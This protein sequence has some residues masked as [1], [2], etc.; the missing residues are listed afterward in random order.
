MK[1]FGEKLKAARLKAGLTQE[2]VAGERMATRSLQRLED[3]VG[4]PTLST[5]GELA[6]SLGI[7]MTD[8]IGEKPLSGRSTK[9]VAKDPGWAE[10]AKVLHALSKVSNER[11]LSVL[12]LLLKDDSYLRELQKIPAFAQFAQALK[13][14]P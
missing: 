10:A 9:S 5:V 11:R 3:G 13:K 4:N 7:S 1:I 8:L 12:Y 2:K 14:V 6:K